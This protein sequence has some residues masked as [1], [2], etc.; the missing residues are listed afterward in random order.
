MKIYATGCTKQQRGG[1]T[2]LGYEPVSDLFVKALTAL[3]HEVD[4]GAHPAGTDL[5][6]YDLMLIGLVPFF[7]IA[8]NNLY[9]TLAAI[10]Q[11]KVL[12]IPLIFYF[13]D[14]NFP[15]FTA[16][17]KTHLRY[18]ETQLLKP[19]FKSRRDYEW[20]SEP[21]HARM[22]LQV[23]ENLTNPSYWPPVLIP[24]FTWGEHHELGDRV[25]WMRDVTY[26]DVSPLARE[27]EIERA[28][29]WYRKRE[30]VLGTVSN[31]LTWLESLGLTWDLNHLGGRASRAPQKMLERDLVGLYGLAWGVLS[32]PYKRILGTGWWRNRFVYAARAGA[33]LLCDPAEAPQLG[34]PYQL[35]PHVVEKMTV[36]QLEELVHAQRD[37]F[38]KHQAGLIDVKIQVNQAIQRAQE[39]VK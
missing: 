34:E 25:P 7:S 21:I 22:L 10:N 31:Q 28:L 35:D 4:H 27:Y 37:A 33:L 19:F 15:Q 24:A 23:M 30:W 20:A 1:G 3:G 29:P 16:N 38:F 26:V 17:V 32:P 5:S 11:A 6:G 13:D 9:P 36:S 2:T 14:W 12:G 39:M 18:G 8:S